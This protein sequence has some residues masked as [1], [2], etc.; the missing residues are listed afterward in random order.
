MQNISVLR[1]IVGLVFL[2]LFACSVPD[3]VRIVGTLQDIDDKPLSGKITMIQEVLGKSITVQVHEVKDD[4]QFQF[5]SDSRGSLVLR[6]TASGHASSEQV[7]VAGTMS[8]DE[9]NFKLTPARDI[10]FRVLDANSRGVAGAELRI[11]R[12]DESKRRILFDRIQRSDA[13][14]RVLLRNVFH[15]GPVNVDVLVPP[16]FHPRSFNVTDLNARSI[17]RE[18]E[19]IVL[20]LGP[21]AGTAVDVD[22]E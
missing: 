20:Q 16:E 9:V 15:D 21:S 4:G 13:D 18:D 6:A 8:E 12:P 17:Q 3:D 22:K 1:V 5:M 10:R 7:V 19:D 2:I 11:R 14:G